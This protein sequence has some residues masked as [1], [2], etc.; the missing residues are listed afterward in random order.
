MQSRNTW[1]SWGRDSE[2][3]GV[4]RFHFAVLWNYVT[5]PDEAASD[6]LDG[7]VEFKGKPS[8][9][10]EHRTCPDMGPPFCNRRCGYIFGR[11]LPKQGDGDGLFLED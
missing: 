7:Q 11:Q 3:E 4:S 2:E 10:S 8:T 6:G 9:S 1:V 5:T